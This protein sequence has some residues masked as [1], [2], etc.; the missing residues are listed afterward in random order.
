MP[1]KTPERNW[2]KGKKLSGG[3]K[4]GG[5]AAARTGFMSGSAASGQRVSSLRWRVSFVAPCGEWGL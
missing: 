5:A 1:V 4:L 3:A 2:V